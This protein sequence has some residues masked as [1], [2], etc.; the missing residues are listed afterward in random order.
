MSISNYAK[1]IIK[2][3]AIGIAV[4]LVESGLVL[5]LHS[6]INARIIEVSR[7][8]QLIFKLEKEKL[9]LAKLQSDFLKIE[10][11]L[12][13]LQAAFPKTD[14]LFSVLAEIDRLAIRTG[15]RQTL[16]VEGFAPRE[17]DIPGLSYVPFSAKLEGSYASLRSYLMELGRAPFFVEINSISLSSANSIAGE[18][19]INITGKIFLKP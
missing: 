17:S 11:F 18:G 12:P 2:I 1:K 14:G 13:R 10:E 19:G 16:A 9:E 4:L 3:V 5:F 8:R 7:K 15:N 6:K